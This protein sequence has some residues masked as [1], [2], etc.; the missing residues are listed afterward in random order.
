MQ[1]M[2]NMVDYYWTHYFFSISLVPKSVLISPMGGGIPIVSLV[3]SQNIENAGLLYVILKIPAKH[4]SCLPSSRRQRNPTHCMQKE[5]EEQPCRGRLSYP[6]GVRCEL[7]TVQLA[8]GRQQAI[9]EST[10]VH[11][12]PWR[13]GLAPV[14]AI[15]DLWRAR[16]RKKQS[17]PVRGNSE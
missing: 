9:W 6:R 11:H 4:I 13:W 5:V 7:F 17:S 15:A 8:Q 2:G 14:P 3:L 16:C 1:Y 12:W 10:T